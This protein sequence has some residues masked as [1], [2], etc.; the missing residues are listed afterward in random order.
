MPAT[1]LYIGNLPDNVNK[2]E[3]EELFK[4]YGSIVEF[5]VLKDYGFIV[6]HLL[7]VCLYKILLY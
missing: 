2:N 5:D 1:K 4:K 6:S 7:E 3:L